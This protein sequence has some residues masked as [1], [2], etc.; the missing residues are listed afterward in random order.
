MTDVLALFSS[1]RKSGNSE[2]LLE[3]VLQG[4]ESSGGQVKRVRLAE[5]NIHSC[6]GCGGCDKTGICVVEDDMTSLYDLIIQADRIILASPIYFYGITAQAK[7]F[8][9]RNQALWNRKR[10]LK[11]SGQRL[12]MPDRKGYL[13]SVAATHG[14]RV[15]EGAVLTMK[16]VYDAMDVSYGGDFLVKGVE[17]RG[18]MKKDLKTLAEAEKFG[19]AIMVGV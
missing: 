14:S 19:R 13:V 5:L 1:P 12:G 8:V 3:S 11:E 4:V 15:F 16:Y 18:E 10:L 2:V 7:A 6:I 9:D 17:D